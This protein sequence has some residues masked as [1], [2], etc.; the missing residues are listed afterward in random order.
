MLAIQLIWKCEDAEFE[1]N[2]QREL[3]SCHYVGSYCKTE[4]LGQCIEKREAHCCF[5]SPLSRIMQEQVRLQTGQGWGSA[6][7]PQCGG[8]PVETLAGI[9]WEAVNLDEWLA[10][11][12]SQGMFAG[13]GNFDMESLTG[14][15]S[16]LDVG[17][18]ENSA[19]RATKRFEDIDIDQARRSGQ[20]QLRGGN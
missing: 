6:K 5:T 13:D 2:A 11:L 4:V 16:A 3:E 10:L 9:D 8:I 19:E 14:M 18:R 12:S 15:G 7:S 1:M 20:D 17:D